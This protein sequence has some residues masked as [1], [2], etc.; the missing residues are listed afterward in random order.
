MKE[1]INDY[2]RFRFAGKDETLNAA[3]ERPRKLK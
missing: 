3:L 2:I 1:D